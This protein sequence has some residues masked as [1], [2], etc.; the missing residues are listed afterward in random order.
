M[1]LF[2]FAGSSDS[3]YVKDIARAGL[4]SGFKAL[5]FNNRGKGGVKLKV[6]CPLLLK[7]LLLMHTS[8]HISAEF[9]IFLVKS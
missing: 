4:K 5:V 2:I 7:L 3:D 9:Y 6:G 1:L 8:T